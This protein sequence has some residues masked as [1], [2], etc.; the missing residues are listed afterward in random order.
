M[1]ARW[2]EIPRVP[3]PSRPSGFMATHIT[4]LI[5]FEPSPGIQLDGKKA[6]FILQGKISQNVLRMLQLS[7]SSA[8]NPPQRSWK[9]LNTRL[10]GLLPCSEV[11]EA[12]EA[13]RST[14]PS[15]FIDRGEQHAAGAP[16]ALPVRP[17]GVCWHLASRCTW[18]DLESRPWA[19][20]FKRVSGCKVGS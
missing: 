2:R 11:G 18:V 12:G 20:P 1:T 19:V 16:E 3:H 8:A 13:A 4:P 10:D 14:T 7:S 5:T 9:L 6:V 15:S 17:V